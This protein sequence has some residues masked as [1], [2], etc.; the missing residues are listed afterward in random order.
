MKESK[1][2]LKI[3][4]AIFFVLIALSYIKLYKNYGGPKEINDWFIEEYNNG[5]DPEKTKVPANYCDIDIT[6]LPGSPDTYTIFYQI[7]RQEYLQYLPILGIIVLLI[8]S[9]YNLNKMFKS[10]YLYY[11]VQRKDYKTFIKSMIL[12]SYK[13]VLVVPFIT[14]FSFLLS[15]TLSTHGPNALSEAMRLATFDTI[16]YNTPFFLVFYTIYI[17]FMWLAYINTGLIVQSRNRKMIF[18]IIEVLIIYFILEM[19]LENY[20][21]YLW[22]FDIYNPMQYSIFIY[23]IVSIVY[24]IISFSLVIYTYKNKE[25]ELMRIGG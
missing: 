20:P 15:L 14:I 23:L 10:K 7:M 24:F 18:N 22:I 9:M 3:I 2:N 25:K 19:I 11:Y 6:G 21:T 13:Y 5:C 8:L 12:Q 16:H 4:F 17:M 1:K